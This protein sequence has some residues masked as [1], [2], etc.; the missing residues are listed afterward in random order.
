MEFVDVKP[1][2]A[3]RVQPVVLLHDPHEVSVQP[4]ARCDA[5]AA[6]VPTSTE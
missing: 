2:T 6:A 3:Q 5:F 4:A 1:G